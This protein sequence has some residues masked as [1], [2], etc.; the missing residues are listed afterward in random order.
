MRDLTNGRTWIVRPSNGKPPDPAP[1]VGATAEPDLL[2]SSQVAAKLGVCVK[3]LYAW[4]REGRFP[5]WDFGP[6]RVSRRWRRSTVEKHLMAE[7]AERKRRERLAD[8]AQLRRGA[9]G[10]RG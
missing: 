4:I 5:S 6:T 8:L 2:K 10:R 9:R 7:E 3:T 1:G